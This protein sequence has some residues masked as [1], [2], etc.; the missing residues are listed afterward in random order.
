MSGKISQ[1][2]GEIIDRLMTTEIRT[3][4]Y[5]EVPTLQLYDAARRK[6]KKPLSYAAAEGIVNNVQ[7]SDFVLISAGFVLPL[8]C[9]RSETDGPPAAVA[10]ARTICTAL[11]ARN[12]LLTDESVIPVMEAG[13]AAAGLTQM[14]LDFLKKTKNAAVASG[15][16][17][18][19]FPIDDQE[20]KKKAKKILDKLQPKAIITIERGGPNKKGVYHTGFGNDMSRNSA[21]LHH[22]IDLAR[23]RGIFTAG[24]LD[25]GNEIG[26]GSIK[27]TVEKVWKYGATCQCPCGAGIACVTET[28]VPVVGSNSAWGAFGVGACISGLTGNLHAL[29]DADTE[30]RLLIECTRAGMRDAA[31]LAPTLTL[32]GAHINDY[33]HL[34]ELFRAV[35]KY[36]FITPVQPTKLRD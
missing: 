24:C 2:T 8:W 20:A 30:R 4:S 19:S 1:R 11:G 36:A 31:T 18:E 3:P 10:L 21:K 14:P 28:D 35:I 13:C 26:S 25:L 17:I 23:S 5:L 6:I 34:I 29:H 12:V 27:E 32:S 33:G 15:V 22:L 9:P 16:A 7:P